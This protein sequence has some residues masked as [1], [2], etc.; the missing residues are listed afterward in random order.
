MPASGLPRRKAS[1][2]AFLRAKAHQRYEAAHARKSINLRHTQPRQEPEVAED[3]QV[4]PDLAVDSCRPR[5]ALLQGWDKVFP[6]EGKRIPSARRLCFTG[7]KSCAV[8]TKCIS[9]LGHASA[10]L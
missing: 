9:R 5:E 1:N 7:A 6:G 8:C 2:S 10:S 4:L 3:Q